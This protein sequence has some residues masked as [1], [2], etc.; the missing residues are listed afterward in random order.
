MAVKFPAADLADLKVL[1]FIC[2]M[3]RGMHHQ[4]HHL[5]IAC[6]AHPHH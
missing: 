2:V 1:G 5:M 3:T 4:D 6:G